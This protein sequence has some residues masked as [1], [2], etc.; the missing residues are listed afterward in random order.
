[1]SCGL[2]DA[3][4][5][6]ADRV[7]LGIQAELL[8]YP[9]QGRA[10]VVLVE[11]DKARPD[12]DPLR[13]A[14][15]DLDRRRVERADPHLLGTL[16]DKH[17]DPAAHLARGLVGEGHRQQTVGPDPA[18]GDQ[19]GDP[20]RQDAGLAAARAGKDEER[21]VAVRDRLLLGRV[22]ALEQ[23]VNLSLGGI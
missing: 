11:D 18:G 6:G 9:P 16:A 21:A 3:V 13:L 7:A 22:E 8:E 20:R 14:A 23:G 10:G 12:A 15:K 1:M 19:V 4:A 2:R 17:L 5:E